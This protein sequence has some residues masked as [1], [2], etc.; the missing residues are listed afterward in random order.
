MFFLDENV[1]EKF[2]KFYLK[3]FKW[4]LYKKKL[5]KLGILMIV[6]HVNW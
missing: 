3:V 2:S 4:C 1:H 5:S 6:M